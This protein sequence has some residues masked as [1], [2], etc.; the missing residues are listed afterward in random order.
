MT[1]LWRR[2]AGPSPRV[3]GIPHDGGDQHRSDGSIPARAGNPVA[4][5]SE[6]TVVGVHPRACGESR[7]HSRTVSTGT[8]P[9][10]R[11]RGILRDTRSPGRPT[12]SIPARAG[13]PRRRGQRLD[14][15]AVHP[16]A[17]GESGVLRGRRRTGGG[18]SPR[19][20]GIPAGAPGRDRGPAS[21]PARAG[22]PSERLPGPRLER[23]H[24]RACGESRCRDAAEAWRVGPSPRV[25]GIP[26]EALAAALDAHEAG[27]HPR[28]CGES[29]VSA[30][31]PVGT[32]GPS[33]R[34]RG[35]PACRGGPS[36]CGWS[37]PARAGNP[38]R[39]WLAGGGRPGPSPRVRGIPAAHRLDGARAGSIPARAGNPGRRRGRTA[40]AW[41][42]PR[43]CGESAR[44]AAGP[45]PAA[46]P[47]PR[48]RGI[49]PSGA[50]SGLPH[51]SIPARTGNPGSGRCSRARPWVHP[52]ACGE[53]GSIDQARACFGGPSP[54]VRGIP[55]AAGAPAH[56]A[57]SIPARAGNPRACSRPSQ[58]RR[59]HPRACGESCW[60]PDPRPRWAGPSPRVRGIPADVV[61]QAPARGS[62]PARAGNP[63]A[64]R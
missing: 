28:A 58:N 31:N 16:R 37:I 47:S 5:S 25:R 45:G 6:L 14:D 10:P 39:R 23:V 42:H 34:V 13:N 26:E 20:R 55:D 22:N 56:R 7:S 18:P 8:G 21:I 24:P 43:A 4:A 52:R 1:S 63:R 3:R 41:V 38:R 30:G 54:R 9:S 27:V 46:G 40:R 11:V 64:R 50:P 48:V 59:V 29:S 12:G 36:V 15:R 49:R 62:I 19:V 35:I 60:R 32:P 61:P 17:C 57:G 2:A 51:G 53:S 33:P 44:S